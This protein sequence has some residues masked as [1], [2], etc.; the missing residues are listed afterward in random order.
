LTAFTAGLGV[1][2]V[3]F[4]GW[5]S[6]TLMARGVSSRLARGC[7]GGGCVALG[8]VALAALPWID[9]IP[10]KVFVGSLG[11][12]LPSII[13]VIAHAVVSEITPVSQRGAL[14][15]I[16]NA[17]GTMA[18]LLAPYVM[19]SMVQNATVPLDGF[20]DGFVICGVVML[21]GGIVGL[22]F[23]RPERDAQRLVAGSAAAGRAA[24]AKT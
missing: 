8:G 3:L 2:I 9:N 18:G 4:L 6:Q 13:Y 10:L 19:G 21:V 23:M 15:S 12:S 11:M 5:Y 20:H 14:L 7:L 1:I 22:T 17:I 24:L 16:G